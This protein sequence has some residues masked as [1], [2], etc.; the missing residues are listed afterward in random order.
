MFSLFAFN[1]F[2]SSFLIFL[3]Q[4]IF[5]QLL[6]PHLGNTPLVWN[7]SMIFYQTL[8]LLGYLY[9]FALSKLSN[10]RLKICLHLSI[11]L[12]SLLFI[13]V[14]LKFYEDID[15]FVFP[16]LWLFS[17]LLASICL[18]FFILSANAPLNQEWFAVTSVS[19]HKVY[20][21]YSISNLGNLIALISYPVFEYFCGLK[22]Q[23]N[24]FSLI[25]L[26]FFCSVIACGYGV[27]NYQRKVKEIAE[28]SSKRISSTEIFRWLILSFIPSS[29]MIG[30]TNQLTEN[31]VNSAIFWLLPLVIY[32]L[33]YILAFLP[34]PPFLKHCRIWTPFL[35]LIT[36][37]VGTSDIQLGNIS[38]ALDL[39]CFFLTSYVLT[40]E[41]SASAPD[42][43]NLTFFY[44]IISFGSIL[45][46]LF[47]SIIAPLIFT[48][49]IEYP[50]VLL[51][52]IYVIVKLPSSRPSFALKISPL[53]G[54][55]I[56]TFFAIVGA[57]SSNNILLQER[58]FFGI[59][60]IVV[61]GHS[62]FTSLFVA[63]KKLSHIYELSE[64]AP[65]NQL[66]KDSSTIAQIGAI[67]HQF[68]S[69]FKGKFDYFEP[70]EFIKDAIKQGFVFADNKKCNKKYEIYLGDP[71]I[72]LSSAAKQKYQA[73]IFDLNSLGNSI[74]LLDPDAIKLYK[75]KLTDKNSFMLFISSDHQLKDSLVQLAKTIDMQSYN[76]QIDSNV[77]YLVMINSNHG[78]LFDQS[79]WE[80]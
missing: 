53:I 64:L 21:L 67:N 23:Q 40:A 7:C 9:A 56:F 77:F 61:N 27:M 16:H 24:I 15:R 38:Y 28:E 30:V 11:L 26:L 50:L 4:P 58:N 71:R 70:N 36:I 8:L 2:L 37:A 63:N 47:N 45:G 80:K 74:H 55:L 6:L 22:L 75:Q 44:L 39:V 52:T 14:D 20:S 33:S 68:C 32:L 25:Y 73:I 12:L 34:S 18:I 60:K 13:P 3:I 79:K 46:S 69:L 59:N 31:L 76:I 10:N 35:A 5:T 54:L 48:S 66:V 29:L 51:L 42:K 65:L 62:E 72:L 17:S 78:S 57:F 19:K 49:L 41:L 43:K 1:I